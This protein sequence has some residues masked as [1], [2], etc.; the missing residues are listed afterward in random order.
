ME[1]LQNGA[2]LAA[3]AKR[4]PRRGQLSLTVDSSSELSLPH[5]PLPNRQLDLLRFE[6]GGA[7]LIVGHRWEGFCTTAGAMVPIG[8]RQ[9]GQQEFDLRRGDYASV[10]HDDLRVMIKIIDEAPDKHNQRVGS[11]P[12]YR[13]H[14]LNLFFPT[15]EEKRSVLAAA[16]AATVI[17]S[18]LCLGLLQR[19][20][21]RPESL[22]EI[23]TVYSLPFVS[24][25]HLRT[26]PETLQ[27]ALDR[28][29]YVGSVIDFYEHFVG[30][31][32]GWPTEAGSGVLPSTAALYRDVFSDQR[33]Q[34]AENAARQN[35][36]DRLQ[37]MKQD[38]GVFA[39]PAVEGETANGSMLRLI[40][41]I[42]IL[43]TAM[44]EN[45]GSKRQILGSFLHDPNY[46]F[47][48]YKELPKNG[49]HAQE[50][51]EKMSKSLRPLGDEDRM[52]LEAAGLAESAARGQRRLPA[53]PAIKAPIGLSPGVRYASFV[54][55][56]S[57]N[58]SDEKINQ[59]D[60]QVFGVVKDQPIKVPEPLSGDIEPD[61]VERFIRQNKFQLQ[62]CYDLALRRNEAIAGTME[63][64]WRIDA[65]GSISDVALVSSNIRDQRMAQCIRQKIGSWRFPR[66][67]RGSVEISYP[68]EFTPRRG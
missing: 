57:L 23:S 16:A 48:A 1:V 55:G 28:R 14:I 17:I 2:P 66:P 58:I 8:R 45:L 9:K 54:L 51:L 21:H 22:R 46:D 36:V 67:R 25:A 44:I 6:N 26:A 5:Y 20:V 34:L 43:Q 40:D 50:Y 32:M 10:G 24:P 29:D 68:F 11:D 3:S 59:I 39:I 64:R 30:T 31:L 27:S 18:C 65:R 56:R 38:T 19:P 15:I 61:L 41:K 63:W 60:A 13:R 47:E 7:T 12:A 42:G 53:A 62:L 49:A 35:E 4:L 52:Y 33:Q 37:G